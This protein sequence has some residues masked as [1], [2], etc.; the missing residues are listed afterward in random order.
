MQDV[1]IILGIVTLHSSDFWSHESLFVYELLLVPC[2][3]NTWLQPL[4]ELLSHLS[5]YRL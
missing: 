3:C 5:H 4:W 1:G 2:Y